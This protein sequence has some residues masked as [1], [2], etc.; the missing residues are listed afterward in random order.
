MRP[1]FI[2]YDVNSTTYFAFLL[3]LSPLPFT[4]F[5]IMEE[6]CIKKGSHAEQEPFTFPDEISVVRIVDSHLTGTT[7]PDNTPNG[8]ECQ[9]ERRQ[10]L[11]DDS[12][13]SRVIKRNEPQIEHPPDAAEDQRQ[14]EKIHHLGRGT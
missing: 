13:D 2:L 8:A 11:R 14:E 10:K 1:L 3:S 7:P 5:I 4:H 12:S 6:P 9:C